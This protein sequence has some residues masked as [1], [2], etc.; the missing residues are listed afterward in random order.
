MPVRG[1]NS[2]EVREVLKKGELTRTGDPY[3]GFDKHVAYES[4]VAEAGKSVK[5]KP[6]GGQANSAKSGGPW[7]AKR[8]LI[9]VRIYA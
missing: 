9:W 8:M 1:F 6:L 2:S 3:F 7:G 4:G 5:H